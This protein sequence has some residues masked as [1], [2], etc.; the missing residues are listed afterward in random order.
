MIGPGV[1]LIWPGTNASIPSGFVRETTLDALFAKGAENGVDP[2]TTGGAATHTHTSPTHTHNIVDHNHTGTT[3]ATGRYSD[4]TNGTADAQVLQNDHYHTFNIGGTSGGQLSGTVTYGAVS[5]EPPYRKVIFIRSVG[6]NAVPDGAVVFFDSSTLPS[7]ATFCDGTGG[8]PDFRNKYLKG[9]AAAADSDLTTS[10][11]SLTNVHDITH[12]HTGVTH[13]HSGTTSGA[14]DNNKKDRQIAPP[15]G[16][17][18]LWPHTHSIT[19]NGGT[20]NVNDYSGSLTT[21]E[22]VEPAYRKL[23]AVINNTG[24][25][26]LTK[27]IVC[28]WLGNLADIPVGWRLVASM[29]GKHLKCTNTTSEVGNTGGSNT[30]THGSQSHS[31]TSNGTHTH[32]SANISAHIPSDRLIGNGTPMASPYQNHSLASCSSV[33]AT[34]SSGSTTA[35]SSSNE[36]EYRTVA[37]IEFQFS[38][39]GAPMGLML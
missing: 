28:L 17:G 18:V 9:A 23:N 31:H 33:A 15:N 36:P 11:G 25:R 24:A 19:L 21:T 35:N 26:R 29:E 20:Q 27:G 32:P 16:S 38:L 22:T 4:N 12:G 37:F 14:S 34:Y 3:T 10:F 6:Y 13:T 1:I 7:W 2:D 39:G 30:H 5:N 8:I